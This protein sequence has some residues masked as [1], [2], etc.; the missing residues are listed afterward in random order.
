[1]RTLRR[2]PK[3]IA[4]SPAWRDRERAEHGVIV[5]IVDDGDVVG[6]AG[7]AGRRQS[8]TDMPGLWTIARLA[9]AEYLVVRLH[10]AVFNR[11]TTKLLHVDVGVVERERV[12]NGHRDDLRGRGELS[13][14]DSVS[15]RTGNG[16]SGRGLLARQRGA[17]YPGAGHCSHV[18]RATCEQAQGDRG[19]ER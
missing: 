14:R 12:V 19:I 13:A 4:A 7:K 2:L 5:F 8:S 3:G 16:A 11:L 18:A 10:R 6:R 17:G 9:V 15:Y 1:V